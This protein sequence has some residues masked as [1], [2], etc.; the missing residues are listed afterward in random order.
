MEPRI[1]LISII[2]NNFPGMLLFYRDVMGFEVK[3]QLEEYVEFKSKNVRFAL[4]TNSVMNTA[5]NHASF[6]E[7]R[8]GQVFEL[9]FPV[10]SPSEVDT[11]YA[12]LVKKGASAI[13]APEDVPWNQ[14]AGFIADPDGNI[15][16]IFAEL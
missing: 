7:T 13:K 14:R 1:D 5:T 11:V 8:K 16:E 6:L 10:A 15:H 3:V 4:T 12:L 2:T 9:A